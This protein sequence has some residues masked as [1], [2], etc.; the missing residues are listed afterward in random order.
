MTDNILTIQNLNKSFKY[1]K[2]PTDRLK[3]LL[4]NKKH[5]TTNHA[6]KNINIELK[7]GETLAL[8]GQNGAGK[9]TLLKLVTQVLM[10]DSGAIHCNGRITGLLEL[11]TGFDQN[12]TG[13]ENIYI[14]GQLLGM[15]KQDLQQSEDT[16]IEF[17]ELGNYIDTPVRTYS[18][19]MLMRLGF[20][21]AI[22]ANPAC[23][24]VDEALAVGDARFQQKCLQ[25][26]RGFQQQ[27]GAMLFVSHDLHAVK[28][29]CSR[30]IILYNGKLAYEGDPISAA[31][32][33]Y[34]QMAGLNAQQAAKEYGKR[35]IYITTAKLYGES[36]NQKE[37]SAGENATLNIKLTSTINLEDTTI[38]FK[39]RDRF[40]NDIYGTNSWLLEQHYT[41]QANTHYEQ[42]FRFPLNLGIGKYSVSLSVHTGMYH[43]ENCQHWQE[44][45][46]DF[47][48]TGNKTHGFVGSNFLN[49]TTEQRIH[50]T[51][52]K[53]K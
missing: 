33:Y 45:A 29:L 19:G 43:Q 9:S 53:V 17:A 10:P 52:H 27:G 48:I 35:D 49:T 37:F 21:I 18:S 6:L 22:H 31:N 30:A 44:D 28:Q 4:S 14:N 39:I 26:I 15:S 7:R 2:K 34:Q 13:R 1:Y 38:G 32:V 20:S 47:A 23:F 42:I 8:L 25:R 11:G 5:H 51:S 46:I 12:L 50:N 40:G 24:I 41:F 36:N 16:I 3:E